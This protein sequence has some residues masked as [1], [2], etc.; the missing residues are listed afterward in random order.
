[1][2]LCPGYKTTHTKPVQPSTADR[3]EGADER[4]VVVKQVQLARKKSLDA[5]INMELSL[6]VRRA[7]A[8]AG[9]GH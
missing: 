5:A 9:I 3:L 8:H 1:M 2:E 7:V 4:L 6:W